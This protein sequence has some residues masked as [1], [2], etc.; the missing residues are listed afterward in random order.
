MKKKAEMDV[1]R[2]T[3]RGMVPEV[4]GSGLKGKRLISLH[5]AVGTVLAHDLTEIIPGISKG[6]AFKKGHVVSPD[7]LCRLQR[8]GK[9]HL[10]V[11]EV[12][13]DE[14]HE[15]EAVELLA[16]ALE[17]SGVCVRSAPSEGKLELVASR[18]G[19]LSI[20]RDAL[21]S[22]NMLGEVACAT[23]HDHSVV[24]EGQVV[25]GVR[26]VPLVIRR[27]VVDEAVRICRT[28]G[29]IV[30]VLP[31][32]KPKA[33]VV[34]TGNEVYSGIVEDRFLP[35]IREKIVERGGEV[36]GAF[37]VP[38]NEMK[39]E[40]RLRTLLRMGADLL[41]TTGGMS[42]DPDDVTRFAI[43]NLGVTEVTYGSAAQPG[44]MLLVGYVGSDPPVPV[45]G[46]PAC[47]L[48]AKTT[49][50]DLVLP[51]I[52]AGERIGREAL[53]E[54]GHGGLCMKCPECR[55]PACPFGK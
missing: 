35:L 31:M 9:E 39:I 38:D 54:L 30:R 17:G 25:A 19:L 45:I 3:V 43:R 27:M 2:I 26:A 48:H 1:H 10:F 29:G 4:Q 47:A 52:L 24:R 51:R 23:L 22:F 6:P 16:R 5:E 44:T 36:V 34:V 14:L 20:D 33:G 55:F 49:V 21:L 15:D 41:I 12:G 11:L 18:A 42:V 7:D 46:V 50:L 8:L 13:P 37:L 40:A 53:A 28:S 32:R